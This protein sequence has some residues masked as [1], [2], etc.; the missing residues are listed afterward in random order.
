MSRMQI[1]FTVVSKDPSRVSED[2]GEPRE[3]I[4]ERSSVVLTGGHVQEPKV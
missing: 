2:G 4:R 1:E 3:V